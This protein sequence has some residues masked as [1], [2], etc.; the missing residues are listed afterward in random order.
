MLVRVIEIKNGSNKDTYATIQDLETIIP[1]DIRKT[2]YADSTVETEIWYDIKD[3]ATLEAITDRN[4]F[5]TLIYYSEFLYEGCKI[6]SKELGE[7]GY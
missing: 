3:F 1:F 6:L 7:G 2:T 4:W 5:K